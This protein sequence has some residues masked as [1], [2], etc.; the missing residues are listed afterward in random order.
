MP[1]FRER[2][3]CGAEYEVDYE[4]DP[5]NGAFCKNAWEEPGVL[6][7]WRERHQRACIYMK[8]PVPVGSIG[9]EPNMDS[10]SYSSRKP[11]DGSEPNLSLEPISTEEQAIEKFLNQW[12]A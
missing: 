1:K 4:A 5:S 9:I 11:L 10:Y 3:S 6:I 12:S 7:A 8:D 2:C